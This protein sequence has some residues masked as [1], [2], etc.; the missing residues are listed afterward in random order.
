MNI[1]K[2]DAPETKARLSDLAAGPSC[3]SVT[4]VVLQLAGLVTG[5]WASSVGYS[6]IGSGIGT[7]S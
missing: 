6:G 7:A 1:L 5:R 2:L 3:N 4:V